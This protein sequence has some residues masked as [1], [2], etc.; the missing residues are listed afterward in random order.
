[1]NRY[2]LGLILVISTNTQAMNWLGNYGLDIEVGAD[3][4]YFLTPTNE[5]EVNWATLGFFVGADGST[6]TSNVDFLARI[7]ANRYSD[8]TLNDKPTAALLLGMDNQGERLYSNLDLLYL[9]ESTLETELLD[10][11]LR[12]D[13]RKETVGVAPGL[14]YQLNERNS[15]SANLGLQSVSYSTTTLVDYNNYDLGLS[16]GYGLDETSDFSTNLNYTKYEP[17]NNAGTETAALFFG[18]VKRSSETTTYDFTL[19]YTTVGESIT[20]TGST[21]YRLLITNDHDEL[22]TFSLRISQLYSP[23]SLGIVR[24]ENR[25]A[26]GWV[27]AF[28]EKLQGLLSADY[29]HTTDRDYYEVKPGIRYRFTQRLN[30][31]GSYRFRRDNRPGGN[32]ESNTVL[33]TLSYTR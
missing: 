2:L 21:T 29:L 22:N 31:A 13:G 17:D 20:S 23:S 25:L 8:K 5:S 14:S 32:A 12:V 4:N 30:L 24:L 18:Y 26:L 3:D 6:E 1:M 19:G 9:F 10:S 11:G 33:F 27:H 16:W 15:L 7:N 28:T